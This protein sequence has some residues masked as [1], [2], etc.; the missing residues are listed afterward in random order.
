MPNLTLFKVGEMLSIVCSKKQKGKFGH[1]Q[2]LLALEQGNE[3][4][5]CQRLELYVASDL[6]FETCQEDRHE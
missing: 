6:V 5:V 2:Q 1:L 3:E 4:V